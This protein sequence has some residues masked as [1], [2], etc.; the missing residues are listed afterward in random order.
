MK[1]FLTQSLFFGLALTFLCYQIG[2]ALKRKFNWAVFNPL[3]IASALVIAVLL[4]LDVDYDTYN[5]SAQYITYLLTPTTVCLAVPLYEQIDKLKA[6][7]FAIFGGILAGV[8]ANLAVI[9]GLSMLFGLSHTD[10]VTLLP[11]SITTAIA[12][13][14]VQEYGGVAS[15]T[16]A[17][18]SL[19]AMMG[20][21]MANVICKLFRITDPVA[22]GLALGNAMHATGTACAMELGETQGAMSSLAVAVAGV[23][24][25]IIAPFF[26][27]L[28]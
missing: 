15:I 10:Y 9:L 27:G 24:T 1:E 18:I 5:K 3:L 17:A 26:V 12:L 14:L 16:A 20:A 7:P 8:L 25:V 4:L 22:Q 11:K 13:P 28:Y 23:L 19:T 2:L 21:I 6:H